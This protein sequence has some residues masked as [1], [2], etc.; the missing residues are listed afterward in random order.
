MNRSEHLSWCKQRALEYINNGELGQAW[1]SM[2]SDLSKHPDTENHSAI[3]LGTMLM[4]GRG[5]STPEAMKKFI[6]EFN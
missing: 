5:L 1:A 2:A 3:T 4:M 6:N